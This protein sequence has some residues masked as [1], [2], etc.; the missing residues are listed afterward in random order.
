MIARDRLT[1]RLGCGLGLVSCKKGGVLVKSVGL[2][3]VLKQQHVRSRSRI[4][5]G[6]HGVRSGIRV[7]V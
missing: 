3:V 7:G 2:R 1:F 4:G 6:V 5:V